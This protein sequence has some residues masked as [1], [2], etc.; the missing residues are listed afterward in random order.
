MNFTKRLQLYLLGVGIGI[1]IVYFFFKDRKLDAWLPEGRV[2]EQIERSRV[3]ADPLA[4]CQLNCLNLPLKIIQQNIL[5]GDVHFDESDTRK[6]P[7][8][9]YSIDIPAENMSPFKIWIEVCRDH[10][11]LLSIEQEGKSCDCQMGESEK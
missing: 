8:P 2:L 7:C 3:T 10:A 1:F 9:V 5:E 4:S 6:E 11:K